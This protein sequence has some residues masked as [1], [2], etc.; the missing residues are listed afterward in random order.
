LQHLYL[1]E[2][3]SGRKVS[4]G[5]YAA[6]PEYTGEWRCDLHPRVSPDGRTVAI[7]SAHGGNGRQI[8]LLDISE[9][10]PTPMGAAAQAERRD[11]TRER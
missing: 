3:A 9:A 10:L 1:Y 7:D 5:S 11:T 4:L 2:V 8:Y 6:P